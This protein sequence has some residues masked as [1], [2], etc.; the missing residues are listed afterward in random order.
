VLPERVVA[1]LTLPWSNARP[2][3]TG[4]IKPLLSLLSFLLVLSVLTLFAV[5]EHSKLEQIDFG[6]TVHA[7]FDELKPIDIPF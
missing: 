1:W 2:G 6:T 5:V 4:Q 7:S 3:F